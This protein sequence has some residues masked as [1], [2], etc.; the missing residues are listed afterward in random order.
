MV[1]PDQISYN[2]CFIFQTF[3]SRDRSHSCPNNCH[4]HLLKHVCV[5]KLN[6]LM[7]SLIILQHFRASF[8]NGKLS[9]CHRNYDR[10]DLIRAEKYF[11]IDQIWSNRQ[12]SQSTSVDSSYVASCP[13][14]PMHWGS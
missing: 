3:P 7:T 13:T 11:L 14:L 9:K 5:W 2:T 6:L 10:F 1:N 12:F 4:K 8:I